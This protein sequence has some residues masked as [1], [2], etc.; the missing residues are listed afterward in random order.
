MKEVRLMRL[1]SIRAGSGVSIEEGMVNITFAD[2]NGENQ[3][4][5]YVSMKSLVPNFLIPHDHFINAELDNMKYNVDSKEIILNVGDWYVLTGGG[6]GSKEFL[7]ERLKHQPKEDDVEIR[8][9]P[10][11]ITIHPRGRLT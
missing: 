11:G 5:T 10:G 3:E 6:A 2:E 9:E 4:G 8:Q 1:E 7:F